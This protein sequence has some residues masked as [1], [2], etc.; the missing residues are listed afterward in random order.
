MIPKFVRITHLK[1]K[2]E[3]AKH[4][5]L[6]SPRS[7]SENPSIASEL[8]NREQLIEELEKLK[9]QE[10]VADFR[11]PELQYLNKKPNYEYLKKET[12]Q[13]Q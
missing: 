3:A 4:L 1:K 12:M 2:K 5:D 7:M 11:S 6:P 13:R 9:R 8:K 10:S